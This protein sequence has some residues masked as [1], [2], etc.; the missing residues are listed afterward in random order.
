MFWSKFCSVSILKIHILRSLY[1]WRGEF[2]CFVLSKGRSCLFG[3]IFRYDLDEFSSGSKHICNFI[4]PVIRPYFTLYSHKFTALEMTC[5]K[6]WDCKRSLLG[7]SITEIRGGWDLLLTLLFLC[8][9]SLL[10]FCWM[11]LICSVLVPLE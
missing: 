11:F 3:H 5:L 9:F 6:C 8:S 7:A 10:L 2:A 1:I 4:C